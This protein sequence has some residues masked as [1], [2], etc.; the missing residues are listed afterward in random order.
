[1]NKRGL[2]ARSVV[3]ALGGCLLVSVAGAAI[4]AP[5]ENDDVDINVSI[6]AL[7]SEGAL[8]MTVADTETSLTEVDSADPAL[9][10]FTGVLPTVTVSDDRTDAPEGVYWYVTG[11][12]SDFTGASNEIEAGNLGWAPNLITDNDGEVTEGDVVDTVLDSGVNAVGLEG[13]ELLVLSLDSAEAQAANG[14]W[15]ADAALTLKTL[16]DVT[17]GD[18]SAVL[19]LTLW[20]DEA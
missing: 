9:R 13:E 8:T 11:Q 1:M 16:A 20:E 2:L 19:T 17:P 6:D 7:P 18:Y 12:S 4:A 14:S 10:E 3:G 5:V 15:Q